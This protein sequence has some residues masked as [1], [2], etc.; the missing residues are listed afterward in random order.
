MRLISLDSSYALEPWP[1]DFQK[2]MIISGLHEIWS[3]GEVIGCSE[4]GPVLQTN[5][6][7]FAVAK[8]RVAVVLANRWRVK[9]LRP[10][11]NANIDGGGKRSSSRPIDLKAERV[12]IA[13][14][15]VGARQ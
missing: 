7:K 10:I 2:V 15:V 6:Q 14:D 5:L 1:G 3:G 8:L 9:K 4:C 11:S 12:I 13:A